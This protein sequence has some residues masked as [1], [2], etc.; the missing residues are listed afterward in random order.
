MTMA[1]GETRSYAR[2]RDRGGRLPLSTKLFQGIGAL[3]DTYKNFA[4][5]TFLLFY[6]NQVLGMPAVLASTAILIALVVDAVTDPLVGSYS[7]SLRSR[8]GRRHA[9]MY[10][11]AVPLGLCLYLVFA[12][13]H[14]LSNAGH[15]VWLCTFA[16]GTRVAMTFFQVPWSA[17]FAEFSDDY[18]E[19]SS[20]V[21]FR[22]LCGW[23]GGT[24]FVWCTW[25]FIFPSSPEFTPGHLDPAGYQTFAG[26]VS[27]LVATA[28]LLTTHLTRR[29]IRFLL[30]PT[31]PTPFSLRHALADVA[32]ALRNRDFLVLFLGLL[33][34]SAI[35]GTTSAL[36]IY[37]NT[38]F[39]GL[40]P[41][42]LRWFTLTIVA[43]MM[44][45]V[46]VPI[47][48]ARFDKKTLLIVGMFFLLFNGL[49]M[50]S[51]RFLDVLPENGDP[52]LLRVLIGNEMIRVM[53]GTIVAIMFVSMVADALDAQ[54]LDT[55]RRQEGVFAAALSFSGKAT[56]G[57]GVVAGGLIL[58]YLLGFPRGAAPSSVDSALIIELGVI[59]GM[60]VPLLYVVPFSMLTRYRITREKHAEIRRILDSQRVSGDPGTSTTVRARANAGDAQ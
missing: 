31:E 22:Y 20:I 19:R 33:L 27:V 13:P 6:Y 45:F 48:Q 53:V 9:L 47:L 25:S 42:D 39:W 40:L 7:D 5:G 60:L 43:S 57:I 11:S 58:D 24:T 21:T 12:P 28:A 55:G 23:I 37:L 54:E 14:G 52:W 38:Y 35:G 26:V 1:V 50:F 16:V 30:Q 46:L 15:F 3:P 59:G 17:L 41:E 18:A 34:A 56:S 29:E 32:M 2:E 51:L 49:L 36:E 8:L 10:A 44:A 4:F